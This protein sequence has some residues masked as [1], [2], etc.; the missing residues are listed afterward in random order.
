LSRSFDSLQEALGYRFTR[1]EM[2]ETALTHRSFSKTNNE[3]LEF[4]GDGVLNFVVAHLLFE[5][6]PDADEGQLSRLRAHLVKGATLAV[7]AGRFHLGEYL[8][9]GPGELKSGGFRRASIL[10]GGLE[11]VIG[12]VY[13]DGGYMAAADLIGAIYFDAL[14]SLTLEQGLKDPKTRL[15][16]F[17]QG[18]GESLPEY[19]VLSATGDAHNQ[20]FQVECAITGAAIA[21]QGEGGNRRAA[22]QAAALKALALLGGSSED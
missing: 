9:L 18:R 13:L 21:T 5:R 3:R 19:R 11:A 17:L 15:Q 8:R 12:A 10:A 20:I 1:R 14:A 7:L 22:E 16:E 4:L 2:L 6:F